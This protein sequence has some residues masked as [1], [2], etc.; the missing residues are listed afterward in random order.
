MQEKKQDFLQEIQDFLKEKISG[1]YEDSRQLKKNALFFLREERAEYALAYLQQAFQKE[2]LAVVVAEEKRAFYEPLFER[3]RM[4]SEHF[5]SLLFVKGDIRE[6][7]ALAC[8]SFYQTKDKMTL[9]A[10][11]GTDGKTTTTHILAH[12]LSEAASLGKTHFQAKVATLGTLGKGIFGEKL[13]HAQ[14][15]MPPAQALHQSLAELA[16]AG[17]GTVVMEATSQALLQKRPYGLDY[18]LAIFL[19]LTE[20]HLDVHKTKENYA[21]AKALLFQSLSAEAFSVLNFDDASLSFMLE[22]NLSRLAYFSVLDKMEKVE[23]KAEEFFQKTRHAWGSLCVSQVENVEGGQTFQAVFVCNALQKRESVSF[24]LPLEARYN[25]QN[26]AAALLSAYC[27]GVATEILQKALAC[28]PKVAG[29]MQEVEVQDSSLPRCFLDFAHTEAAIE[30]VLK[31][32]QKKLAVGGKLWVLCNAA[33][34]REREKRKGIAERCFA[35]ADEVVLTLE[36]MGKEN[37]RQI[38]LDLLQGVPSQRGFFFAPLRAEAVR[39]AVSLMKKEDFLLLLSLGDQSSVNVGGEAYAYHEEEVLR[40]SLLE[41]KTKNYLKKMGFL[42][43]EKG[44]M[45]EACLKERYFI[46]EKALL[47]EKLRENL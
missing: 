10:V 9:L 36:D 32:F 1:V 20:D 12:L 17:A 40:A 33:G 22:N 26:A 8:Q 24:F 18:R 5:A 16:E 14:Y 2:V 41:Q 38:L 35:L 42:T 28:L 30:Q 29:R 19:N 11:T 34:D 45:T 6:T 46:Q 47:E 27:L 25:V 15:S 3:V 7:Y 43:D 39:L 4:E 13:Q 31:H 37:P 44:F 21:K 23:E